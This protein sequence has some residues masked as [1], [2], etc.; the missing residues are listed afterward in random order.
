MSLTLLPCQTAWHY[1]PTINYDADHTNE[2][3]C[4]ANA[5]ALFMSRLSGPIAITGILD[6]ERITF[7]LDATRIYHDLLDYWKII[8]LVGFFGLLLTA[9]TGFFVI[10]RAERRP[11]TEL[12]KTIH[13]MADDPTVTQPFP[14]SIRNIRDFGELVQA[15][16]LLQL[17]MMRTLQHRERL[18]EISEGVAKINHDIRNVLSSATLV[19]DALLA[20][21]DENVRRS[22]P[23]VLR[24]L[25]QAV[26]LC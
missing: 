20:S 26:D 15:V 1:P 6:G 19:R 5:V 17:N 16:E 2:L 23:L 13:M 8:L 22:A 12:I 7:T 10:R 3:T 18:A 9:K 4:F 14:D 21:K 25:E 11:I 24:S